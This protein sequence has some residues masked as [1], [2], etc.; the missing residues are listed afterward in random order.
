MSF[1]MDHALSVGAT[2]NRLAQARMYLAFMLACNFNMFSP[3]LLQILLYIQ[4]LGNSFKS[5]RSVRNYVSGARIYLE[6]RSHDIT[7]FNHRLVL[8]LLN[9]LERLSLH[10]PVSAPTLPISVIKQVVDILKSLSLEG[11]I[12]A[13]AILFGTATFLRQSNFLYTRLEEYNHHMVRRKDLSISNGTLWVTVHSTKTIHRTKPVAIAI[14]SIPGSNYCPVQGVL[15]SIKMVPANDHHAI[16]LFPHDLS[17]IPA[18]HVTRLLRVALTILNHPSAPTATVHSTR[19]SGAAGCASAGADEQDI[20]VHGTWRGA[21]SR[22]YAPK[23]L[24]TKTSHIV[25]T[26]LK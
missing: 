7:C 16:F 14:H 5:V 6:E 21:A 26:L 10:V 17:P 13:N 18:Y 3:M 9:G 23:R 1:T 12:A 8:N 19:H 4:C 24:Y 11:I 20:R 2:Q 25:S 15:Q 22:V